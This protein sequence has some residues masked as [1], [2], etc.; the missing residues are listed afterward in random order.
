MQK[1]QKHFLEV[2]AYTEYGKES[3]TF[4]S[5]TEGTLA[6]V[7]SGENGWSW[8]FIFIP[9]GMAKTMACYSDDE[10]W[11]SWDNKAYKELSKYLKDYKSKQKNNSRK[12][13]YND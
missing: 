12:K 2:L 10:R 13:R 3:I 11:K 1:K 4:I 7:P 6:N 9:K 8:D 5:K